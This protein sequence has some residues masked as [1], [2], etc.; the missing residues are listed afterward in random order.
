MPD[1]FLLMSAEVIERALSPGHGE[2]QAFLGAIAVGRVFGA[3]VECH[4]DVGAKSDLHIHGV[5]GREEVT[6]AIAMRAK[7][8]AFIG[9]FAQAAQAKNLKA[10]GIGEHGARPTDEAM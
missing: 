2:A 9:D 5:L 4:A 10:A 7:A 6:A 1:D 8:D 3:F